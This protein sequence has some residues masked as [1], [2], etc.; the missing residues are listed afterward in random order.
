LS[1]RVLQP[2]AISLVPASLELHSVVVNHD[3]PKMFAFAPVWIDPESLIG[4][5]EA[6]PIARESTHD[7]GHISVPAPG[8]VKGANDMPFMVFVVFVVIPRI[9]GSITRRWTIPRF[10]ILGERSARAGGD[11]Q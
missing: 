6:N 4:D 9:L 10:I 3:D 5:F 11:H 8:A 1:S 7:F 2:N